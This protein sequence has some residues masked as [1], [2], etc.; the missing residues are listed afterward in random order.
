MAAE[1]EY[2]GIGT[3]DGAEGC[4]YARS[5]RHS[6]LHL[7]LLPVSIFIYGHADVLATITNILLLYL[8]F[9]LLLLL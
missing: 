4:V 9:R 5:V 6:L 1:L 8:L 7:A 3:L 2:I